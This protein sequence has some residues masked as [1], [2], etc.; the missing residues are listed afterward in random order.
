M[1]EEES[2]GRKETF[3]GTIQFLKKRAAENNLIVTHA[4]IAGKLDIPLEQFNACYISDEAPAEL[5][6]LLRSQYP[7]LIGNIML[8]VIWFT[9][10]IDPPDT[11]D[12]WESDEE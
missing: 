10:V 3:R 11:P 5:F 4:Q 1:T 2:E 8:E 7:D 9:H 6:P 12:P